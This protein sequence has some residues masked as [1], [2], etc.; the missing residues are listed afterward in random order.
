MTDDM[1]V[2]FLLR[3]NLAASAAVLLVL[4]ARPLMRR[5]LGPS[6]AYWLWALVPVAVL[7]SLFPNLRDF[8][9]QG[10]GPAPEDFGVQGAEVLLTLF[11]IGAGVLL[12]LFV[13]GEIRFRR[14]ASQGRAGPAVIG[15][16]WPRMVTPDDYEARFTAAE[17]ELIAVHEHVHIDR[18]HPRHNRLIAVA[19]LLGWFNPLIHLAAHCARLDQEMACDAE[20]MAKAPGRRRLYAETLLK[21][22]SNQPWSAFAC[23]LA[24]GG[25]HP[26]EV[27]IAA[28]RTPP[29]SLARHLV[30]AAFVGALGVITALAIWTLSPQT[31]G[32]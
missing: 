1:I 32:G 18:E 2:L 14:L 29:V 7:T 12:T 13:V 22:H 15:L 11:L 10:P 19:Q 30:A 27:R 28:L 17:R 21:A 25:R 9:A 8:L 6:L 16:N 23:A 3:A 24:D 31:F 20:V 26:L 4:A 5:L